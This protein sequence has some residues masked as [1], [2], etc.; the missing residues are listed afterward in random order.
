M[1]TAFSELSLIKT[2]THTLTHTHAHS[3]QWSAYCEA[4]THTSVLQPVLEASFAGLGWSHL[5]AA[6]GHDPGHQPLL[7]LGVVLLVD[8]ALHLAAQTVRRT[9]VCHD[10]SFCQDTERETDRARDRERLWEVILRQEK[11]TLQV[12]NVIKSKYDGEGRAR[13]M[14]SIFFNSNL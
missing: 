6:L 4:G 13:W 3:L 8:L 10:C 14:P 2:H 12:A 11:T 1:T 9:F 5:G 7:Q